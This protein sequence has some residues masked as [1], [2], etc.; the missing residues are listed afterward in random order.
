MFSLLFDLNSDY[1]GCAFV[2]LKNAEPVKRWHVRYGYNTPEW[3]D[4]EKKDR[5]RMCD[6]LAEMGLNFDTLNAPNLKT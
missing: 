3:L 5:K 1:S 6:E 4:Q 2:L